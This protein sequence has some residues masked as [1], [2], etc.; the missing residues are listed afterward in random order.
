MVVDEKN[1]SLPSWNHQMSLESLESIF[2]HR[3]MK[4]DN[5]NLSS[6]N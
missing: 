3:C 2:L 4:I 1:M 5:W 6:A